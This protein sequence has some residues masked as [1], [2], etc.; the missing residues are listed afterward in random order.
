M[1]LL[2]PASLAQ[3]YSSSGEE[4]GWEIVDQYLLLVEWSE[5]NPQEDW[6]TAAKTLEI[7]ESR[8]QRWYNGQKPHVVKQVEAADMLGWF[9][10]D[11]SSDIGRAFNLLIAAVLSGG[12]LGEEF[13]SGVTLDDELDAATEEALKKAMNTLVGEWKIVSRDDPNRA[14]TLRPGKHIALLG[15]ALHALGVPRGRK[16]GA[17]KNIPGY[18]S[19]APDPLRREFVE[20]YVLLRGA[21][22]E[23]GGVDIREEREQSYLTSLSAL[24]EDVTGETATVRKNGIYL[25]QETVQAL[26]GRVSWTDG[27]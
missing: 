9:D 26:S 20:T 23:T 5:L 19:A 12:Y 13:E 8:V 16:P 18:L 1:S 21:T 24:I 14:T 2:A 22:S 7:P 3:T 27:D 6:R 4:N 25:R 10:A 17:L 11:W 15:R